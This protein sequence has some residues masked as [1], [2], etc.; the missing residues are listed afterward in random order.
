MHGSRRRPEGHARQIRGAHERPAEAANV[1]GRAL[2]ATRATVR[3]RRDGRTLLEESCQRRVRAAGLERVHARLSGVQRV[4]AAHRAEACGVGVVGERGHLHVHA[5][6]DAG[7]V[8]GE[9]P[10]P[11]CSM[12]WLQLR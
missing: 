4:R 8:R 1:G 2:P 7:G 5:H 9:L 11:M 10:L 3:L 6:G 12:R